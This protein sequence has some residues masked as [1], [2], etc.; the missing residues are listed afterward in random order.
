ML[1]N[2]MDLVDATKLVN[3]RVLTTARITEYSAAM[4]R[5]L[6]GI[7]RLYPHS[8]LLPN[9]HLSLHL[10][11]FLEEF[12]PTNGWRCFP[13]ERYNYLLQQVQTNGKFG[14]WSTGLGYATTLTD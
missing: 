2:F 14:E 12:G 10:P 6:H 1:V 8:S 4:Q 7:L 13:F 11:R 5:Y 9:H 3:M